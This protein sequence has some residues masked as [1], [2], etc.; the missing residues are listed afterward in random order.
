VLE[1]QQLLLQQMPDLRDCV[2]VPAVA[3]WTVSPCTGLSK[4]SA[5]ADRQQALRA[6]HTSSP[7]RLC[8]QGFR[9]AAMPLVFAS[10]KDLGTLGTDFLGMVQICRHRENLTRAV[11][12]P[13]VA[14]R[15]CKRAR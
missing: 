3:A 5:E 4:G 9:R 13:D 10:D 7:P 11:G 15:D 2:G 14:L 8:T 12:R 6:V 1:G